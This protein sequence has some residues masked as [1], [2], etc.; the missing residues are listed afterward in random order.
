MSGFRRIRDNSPT[1]GPIRR[2]ARRLTT[3]EVLDRSKQRAEQAATSA[4]AALDRA[5][6][7]RADEL[8]GGQRRPSWT[9][10]PSSTR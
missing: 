7:E 5:R 1:L 2:D 4:V 9:A 3:A 8:C 10:S 6:D